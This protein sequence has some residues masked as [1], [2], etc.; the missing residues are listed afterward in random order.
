MAS[1]S[2]LET[3]LKDARKKVVD[4]EQR[5]K[6]ALKAFKG[7]PKLVYKTYSRFKPWGADGWQGPKGSLK[8]IDNWL[9]PTVDCF[10]KILRDEVDKQARGGT[11]TQEGQELR[12]EDVWNSFKTKGKVGSPTSTTGKSSAAATVVSANDSVSSANESVS[13]ASGTSEPGQDKGG[14]A[15]M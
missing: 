5:V 4:A 7:N 1:I 11:V 15:V 3:R 14:C 12:E 13:Q 8:A 6:T 9:H 10:E 2:R